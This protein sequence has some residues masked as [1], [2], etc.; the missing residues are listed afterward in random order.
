[1][2]RSCVKAVVSIVVLQAVTL[3]A[4]QSQPSPNVEREQALRRLMVARTDSLHEAARLSGGRVVRTMPKP[5]W[6]ATPD[7]LALAETSAA[8][9]IGHPMAGVPQLSANG[10]LIYTHYQV[11]VDDV[12]K[13]G[14]ASSETV[15]VRVLGGTLQFADGLV[16]SV[17]TPGFEG[18]KAGGRY[19][20]FLEVLDDGHATAA[21]PLPQRP[22]FGLLHGVQ[23]VFDI[24]SGAVKSGAQ[25]IEAVRRRHDGKPSDRFLTEVR[26]AV[27]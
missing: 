27:R 15:T 13:G 23:G 26:Q 11:L 6:V 25:A 3:V 5:H 20:F 1:M 18:L 16:A 22:V 8:V 19:V 17:L 10:D 12:L 4:G 24:S 14:I 21:R 7:V 2:T 9:V